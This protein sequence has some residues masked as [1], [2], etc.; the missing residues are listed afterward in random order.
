MFLFS[1]KSGSIQLFTYAILSFIPGLLHASE[2]TSL[3]PAQIN[4][5]R[6]EQELEKK[7]SKVYARV[8]SFQIALEKDPKTQWELVDLSYQ[9]DDKQRS[10]QSDPSSCGM[11]RTGQSLRA[12]KFIKSCDGNFN[13]VFQTDGNLVLYQSGRALWSSGTHGS[14]ATRVVFQEDGNLVIYGKTGPV[15]SSNTFGNIG[16]RLVVQN[17]GNVVVY[18]YADRPLWASN[19]NSN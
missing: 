10:R 8:R 7:L 14:G 4:A 17:D 19:S 16:A 11:L 1:K 13:L 12:G 18:S 15:W 2:P 6:L 5:H 3:T 9:L